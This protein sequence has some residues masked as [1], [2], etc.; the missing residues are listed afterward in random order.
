MTTDARDTSPPACAWRL[1]DLPTPAADA[2]AVFS[3]FCC[4]GGSTM[5]YKLAGYRSEGGCDIDPQMIR[6]Y[7]RNLDPPLT[8][9]APV[10]E[11][12]TRELPPQLFALDVLDGSP[13][14]STFSLAGL[15][16][17]AW[18]REKQFREGQRVQVLDDLFFDFLRV[19]NRLRPRVIVAENVKGMMIGKAKG[20]LKAVVDA[21]GVMEY[22]AQ[23]FLLNAADCG[24]P[25]R[26]ERIFIVAR[27]R[28]Q[29][30]PALQLD[31]RERWVSVR[32]ALRDLQQLTADEAKSAYW[33]KGG[34]DDTWWHRTG[35]GETYGNV[36]QRAEGRNVAFNHVRL[37][38]DY[39]APTITAQALHIYKHWDTPRF[40]TAREAAR[41]CD[42]PMDYQAETR[43]LLSYM[44]GMS[45]PPHMMFHVAKAIRDQWLRPAA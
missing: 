44:A 16:E 45:V 39:P 33:K 11:L 29:Q 3:T 6:H 21:L 2:P 30:F 22:D 12:V 8:I 42:F 1:A 32:E 31:P 14:C 17:E 5:G 9:C 25:Q 41:L 43:R 34:M 4:G 26:R 15:R 23:V 38:P 10:A 37:H 27:R 13:P 19:A 36:R 24:V 7:Q 40:L 20:Y 35:Q 28:D 18:G